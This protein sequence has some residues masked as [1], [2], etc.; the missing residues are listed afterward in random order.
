VREVREQTGLT[1]VRSEFA[2]VYYEPANGMHHFTFR[3]SVS[4]GVEPQAD[5]LEIS[6]CGFWAITRLPRPMFDFTR[7]RIRDA[8]NT[9]E[10][11]GFHLVE[12]RR[13]LD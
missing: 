3:C 6:E 11:P 5:Q 9:A 2:G 7:S 8:I 4:E 13:L 10:R 12:A 1:V